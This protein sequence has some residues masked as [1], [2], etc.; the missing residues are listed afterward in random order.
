MGTGTHTPTAQ[1]WIVYIHGGYFRDPKVQASSFHPALGQ[2]IDPQNADEHI[3]SVQQHIQGYASINYRLS[4]HQGYPQGDDVSNYERREAKWPE[5]LDD[6][7]S[8]IEWL[9]AKY[10][11]GER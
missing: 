10:G 7:L 6:V 9:Q 4:P 5:Q 8:A 11:F 3:R 2:L 1:Y